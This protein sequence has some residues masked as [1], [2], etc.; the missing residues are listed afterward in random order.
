MEPLQE[1]STH[2]PG[3][4]AL[5]PSVQLPSLPHT[6]PSAEAPTLPGAPARAGGVAEPEVIPSQG[7]KLPPRELHMGAS[8]SQ[9]RN[10]GETST[11]EEGARLGAIHHS[12]ACSEQLHTSPRPAP[13]RNL[14]AS[15]GGGRERAV[16]GLAPWL[17]GS[18]LL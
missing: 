17:E 1:D 14:S 4:L 13:G 7:P 6:Q 15:R 12:A 2:Q 8:A 3:F 11:H 16:R 9:P 5:P 10:K 18:I